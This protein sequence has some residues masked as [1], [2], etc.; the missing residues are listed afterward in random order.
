MDIDSA[1]V[2]T[3]YKIAFHSMCREI[4]NSINKFKEATGEESVNIETYDYEYDEELNCATGKFV[5]PG[6]KLGINV[7]ISHNK[8]DIGDE[9]DDDE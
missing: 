1:S 6:R 3:D 9:D 4:L 2:E 8:E 5:K 7:Y